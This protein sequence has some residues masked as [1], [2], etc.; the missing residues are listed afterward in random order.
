MIKVSLKPLSNKSNDW[1]RLTLVP[2]TKEDEEH[3]EKMFITSSRRGIL[4]QIGADSD[5]QKV[6]ERFDRPQC[7]F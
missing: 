7:G 5:P 2:E 1:V 3:L 6:T 4:V